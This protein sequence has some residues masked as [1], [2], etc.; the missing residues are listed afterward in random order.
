MS[1][2]QVDF[3]DL[4]TVQGHWSE[5]TAAAI[6]LRSPDRA[7]LRVLPGLGVLAIRVLADAGQPAQRSERV[8]S[9][10][11]LVDANTRWFQLEVR[12]D[13]D[14]LAE[15]L[16]FLRSVVERIAGNM[17]FDESVDDALGAYGAILARRHRLSEEQEIGLI[18]ELLFLIALVRS[19]VAAQDAVESWFGPA[20]GEHDFRLPQFDVE[21][22]TTRSER[23]SHWISSMTQLKPAGGRELRLLSIQ[24]TTATPDIGFTLP[25]VVSQALLICGGFAKAAESLIEPRFKP[26]EGFLY[27]S[28]WSLRTEPAWFEV[29]DSFPAIT[30]EL[31]SAMVPSP[32]MVVELR[33]RIDL[34]TRTPSAD[35]LPSL[36][37]NV[38]RTDAS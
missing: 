35:T 14:E 16:A 1:S 17:R 38:D 37:F 10:T 22:K 27:D 26:A 30:D 6:A 28:H 8:L 5:G 11:S 25:D 31:V 3:P 20:G 4:A 13:V 9:A 23:R 7:T 32:A 19:G 15:S 24:L 21:A 2:P 12:T 18:G 36:L 34:T 29:D 33:Y